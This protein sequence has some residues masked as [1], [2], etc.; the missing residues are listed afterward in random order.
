MLLKLFKKHQHNFLN[1]A[2]R[3][4][5]MAAKMFLILYMGRFFSLSEIGVYGLVV[6]AISILSVLIGQDMIFFVTRD[7]VGDDLATTLHKMRDQAIYYMLNYVVLGFAILF[8][9]MTH[10]VDIPSQIL[11]YT[12]VLIVLESL[13]S[14]SYYNMNSM[15]QQLQANSLFFI[16]AG[17]WVLPAIVLC[18]LDPSLQNADT[19]LICWIGGSAVSLLALLWCWRG[20]PWREVM[21][22]PVNWAWVKNGVRKSSLIW[23]GMIGLTCGAFVDRFVVE[24]FLTIEDVGV[25][26]FYFSFTNGLLTLMQS[27]ISAFAT[28]RMILHHRNKASAEFASEARQA[29]K[30]IA[31]SSGVLAVLLGVA[32][33]LLGHLL[34]RDVFYTNAIVFWMMLFGTFLRANADILNNI[35]YARHQDRAI[36]LG[37]LLYLVPALGCSLIFIPLFHFNGVGYGTIAASLFL[38][39]W[40]WKNVRHPSFSSAKS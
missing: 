32:V 20:M 11:F 22:R 21:S 3:L 16:R 19:V 14:I 37:N 36:W 27:G 7:I 29:H 4:L 33:P 17:L 8:V 10:I 40:R 5:P 35:L 39:L 9:A 15:N 18:V 24:H 30:Q 6:G 23:L 26:T 1:A 28:P 25:L 12:F 34:G 13:G 38:L 2:A 31:I